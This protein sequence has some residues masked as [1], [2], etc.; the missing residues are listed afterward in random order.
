V[1]KPSS[2]GKAFNLGRSE[3]LELLEM[4]IQTKYPLEI[5]RTNNLNYLKITTET[6]AKEF[7]L[8]RIE[9]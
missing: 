3:I 5:M 4:M 8:N 7:M 6:T 2:I 9:G 1:E